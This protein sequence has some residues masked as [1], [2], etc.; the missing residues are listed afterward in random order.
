LDF[1]FGWLKKIIYKNKETM[2]IKEKK[3]LIIEIVEKHFNCINRL[4]V[5]RFS[6]EIL[7]TITITYSQDFETE[8]EEEKEYDRYFI[9]LTYRKMTGFI[10]NE[11]TNTI[12]HFYYENSYFVEDQAVYDDTYD[13]S[14]SVF[15]TEPFICFYDEDSNSSDELF[16][17]IKEKYQSLVIIK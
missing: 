1:Y 16:S 14:D 12:I 8:T 15:E 9:Y 7:D 10:Y 3:L 6:K 17:F 2:N 11:I 4:E 5:D 13:A